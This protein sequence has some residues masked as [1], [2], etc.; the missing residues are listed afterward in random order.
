MPDT[1][2]P[3]SADIKSAIQRV[4]GLRVVLDA[5]LAKFYGKSVSAFNQAVKRNA[6]RFEGYR[7]QLTDAEVA[8]LQSQ[9]VI[10]KPKGRG[11]RRS[12]PWVYND[13][14]VVIASTLFREP[15]AVTITRMLTEA[16]VDAAA[17]VAETPA[18]APEILPPAKRDR[19]ALPGLSGD[20]LRALAEN[21]LSSGEKGLLD[22]IR[23]PTTERQKA[24]AATMKTLAET[25]GVEV[26][27]EQERL[28]LSIARRLADGDY[29]TD[30]DRQT[31]LDLLHALKA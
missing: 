10:A 12:N 19:R 14:G 3:T 25:S 30:A 28:R 13:Y 26:K 7:F 5:D 1:P 4:R 2:L 31:L 17:L 16:F 9:N 18:T 29:T 24:V 15:R 22:W 27:N 20:E 8:A 21:I 6:E 23:S 11:G